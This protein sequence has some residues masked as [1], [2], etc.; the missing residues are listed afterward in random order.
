MHVGVDVSKHFLDVAIHETGELERYANSA[1]GIT[2]FLGKLG[3][4]EVNRIVVEATGRLE[5][6]LVSACSKAKRPIVV[7]NPRQVRDFARASGRLAKTDK[8]DALILA[9]YGAAMCPALLPI[10]NDEERGFQELVARRKQLQDMIT[11]EQSRLH[12]ALDRAVRD[13]VEAM[14]DVLKKRLKN[15]E[16]KISSRMTEHEDWSRKS[17][18][19]L[20]AP[21][22]GQV[23]T[24]T[25]LT[26][27]PE[28][29]HLNRKKICALVGVVPLNRDS[30]LHRGKRTIWGGRANVRATLFMATL[31][32]TR[33]NPVIKRH[34]DQLV[35][36]GKAKKVALIACMRKFLTI[37][38][39]MIRTSTEWTALKEANPT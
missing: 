2:E 11:S 36:R 15:V 34:Y 26:S 27:L 22:I 20:S 39:A 14:L 31:R 25:L 33:C 21:A 12:Q 13:D 8:L 7:I 16:E 4:A 38:N 3:A 5:L 17:E 24:M 18:I 23:T 37:L 10:K 9:H 19:L 32:A 28:L 6:P 1:H 35:A 29:G 30:G